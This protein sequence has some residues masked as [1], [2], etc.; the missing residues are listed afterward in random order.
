MRVR[1]SDAPYLTRE[2]KVAIRMKRKYSKRH[3]KLQTE[4]SD[5][6]R[7]KWR[8][9]ATRLRR[10]AIKQYWRDKSDDLKTNPR[11]F[12]K[13]FTPSLKDKKSGNS[14][15]SLKNGDNIVQ[16][17]QEVSELLATYFAHIADNTGQFPSTS[18]TAVD[19]VFEQLLCN[20]INTL[21]NKVFNPFNSAYRKHYSCET[22]LV[23]LMED[24]TRS[25]DNNMAVGVFLN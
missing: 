12:F 16:D 11:S 2:W 10:N 25:L 8:N 24:R 1:E 19:K 20:Q 13:T 17:Q 22:T 21:T 15:I 4:E 18:T 3:T 23:R 6:L 5:Q 14:G 7:R 9:R